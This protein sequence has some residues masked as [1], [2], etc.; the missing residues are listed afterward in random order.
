LKGIFFSFGQIMKKIIMV[1]VGFGET[2]GWNNII[3]SMTTIF[4]SQQ[5][6]WFNV[7]AMVF[8]LETKVHTLL[9][10]P[11]GNGVCWPYVDS[12]WKIKSL[13]TSLPYN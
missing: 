3:N 5:M 10:I 1:N 9:S 11:F 2:S 4:V 12:L 6:R 8:Y 13:G 7:K